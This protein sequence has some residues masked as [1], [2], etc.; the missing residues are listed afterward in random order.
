[1]VEKTIAGQEKNS[2]E[3]VLI[4]ASNHPIYEVVLKHKPR[5][6]RERAFWNDLKQVVTNSKVKSF[7][8]PIYDASIAE[9][10]TLQ[11]V[12]GCKPAV[13]Y[14]YNELKKMVKK[15]RIRLGRKS[16]YILFLGMLIYRLIKEGW[17]EEDAWNAVCT[18]SKELGHYSDSVD[19]KPDFEL[20]GSREV[21]SWIRDRG[22][23][24]KVVGDDKYI[25]LCWHAGG[26][27]QC[28][29]N[30]YPLADMFCIDDP[31]YHCEHGVGW[32]VC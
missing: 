6:N 1:M 10:G 20:T 21:A 24:C 28:Y 14:S 12:A 3:T 19:A 11:F 25:N 8:V 17:S 32:F 22:N 30:C 4:P 5:N 18:D 29:G 31:D 13:G 2:I 16:Q 27:Y 7:L 23:A 9:D 15:K 26:Y